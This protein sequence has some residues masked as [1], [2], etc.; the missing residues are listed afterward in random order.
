MKFG[1]KVQ[2]Y[3][4]QNIEIGNEN[5]VTISGE[6]N[7]IT[8]VAS[9]KDNNQPFVH[10]TLM[11]NSLP[12]WIYFETDLTQKTSIFGKDML[13]FDKLRAKS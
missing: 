8:L 9:K 2:A 1:L 7:T 6:S 12:G 5:G 4:E 11:N 10:L 3:N 13:S